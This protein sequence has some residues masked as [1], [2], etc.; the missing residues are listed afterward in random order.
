MRQPEPVRV[1]SIAMD[2]RRQPGIG[3]AVESIA[4]APAGGKVRNDET[5]EYSLGNNSR[6]VGAD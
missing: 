1:E 5:V 4:F 6:A 2:H 3:A